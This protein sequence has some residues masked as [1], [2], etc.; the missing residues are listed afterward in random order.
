VGTLPT[1]LDVNAVRSW[2]GGIAIVAIV[3]LVAV[4]IT[5]RSV[6]TRL[7][8][9]ALLGAA[10]FGLLHYQETLDHCDKSGC[11]CKLLGEDLPGGSCTPTR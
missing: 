2:A 7:V 8:V 11:A 6:G 3:I 5:V 4:V 9:V 10:V 1:W